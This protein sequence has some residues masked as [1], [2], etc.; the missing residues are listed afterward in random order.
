[1]GEKILYRSFITCSQGY[2]TSMLTKNRKP[3]LIA[4][5][6]STVDGIFKLLR[7][8]GTGTKKSIPQAYVAWRNGSLQFT[9]ARKKSCKIC[10]EIAVLDARVR[11]SLSREN[12]ICKVAHCTMHIL[13]CYVCKKSSFVYFV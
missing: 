11:K 6:R 7:S 4:P 13:H 2:K 9:Q 3:H 12:N 8:P 5:S 1:V 10:R